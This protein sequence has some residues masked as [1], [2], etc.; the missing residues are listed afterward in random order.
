MKSFKLKALVAAIGIAVTGFAGIANAAIANGAS[1]NGELYLTVWDQTGL[2]SYVR[3]LGIRMDS[4]GTQN[5]PP[6]AAFT[7]VVDVN[8][9][10]NVNSGS[11]ATWASFVTGQTAAQ[12]GSYLWAVTAF[13]ANGSGAQGGLRMLYSSKTDDQA[14]AAAPGILGTNAG[15]TN[16]ITTMDPQINALN[17]VDSNIAL[18]NS[19]IVTDATSSAYAGYLAGDF[20]SKLP[21]LNPFATVG[22]SMN[23]MYLTRTGISP[24]GGEA[25]FIKYGNALGASQFALAADGS[26]SYASIAPAVPEPGEW[27]ML[28]AGLAVVGSMARRRLSSHV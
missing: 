26:L 12:V 5:A 10:T 21:N 18:N 6:T 11:D 13:D 9:S 14:A 8:G 20:N 28:L 19:Y 23:F 27:A 16:L 7:S 24:N 4:F 25:Q 15:V 1:G 3:D 17:G 22:E 2:R